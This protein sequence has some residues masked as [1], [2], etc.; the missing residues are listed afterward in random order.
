MNPC[1]G[2]QIPKSPKRPPVYPSG[3]RPGGQGLRSLTAAVER[4]LTRKKKALTGSLLDR[5]KHVPYT[6]CC[7]GLPYG[8]SL[9]LVQEKLNNN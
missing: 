9:S 2:V 3:V 7:Q 8:V 4:A 6:G 1:A 5:L